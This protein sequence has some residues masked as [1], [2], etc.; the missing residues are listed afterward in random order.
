MNSTKSILNTLT[1]E[2]KAAQMVMVDFSGE[3]ADAE[4][5]ASFKRH[6]WGG[7]ILFPKNLKNAAQTANLLHSLQEI[8]IAQSSLPLLTAVDQE[9]GMTAPLFFATA[10]S[11]GNM[12]IAATG[13]KRYAYEAA[14]LSA[15][16]LVN[17]GFNLNFAPVAD[18]NNNSEN[19][20]I[21]VRSFGDD[22]AQ[23][24]E[25]TAEAVRGFMDG[26]I[27]A[28][29][30][31]FPGHGDTK[32]DSHLLLPSVSHGKER[33]DAV[34]LLPFRA[35]IAAGVDSI[36]TAHILFPA[37][38]TERPA[39]LSP[40]ILSDLLRHEMAF[41]GLII[42][43]SMAMKAIA[44]HYGQ[45]EA[46]VQSVM[47]GADIV[48]AC[49]PQDKQVE[50][51]EAL[52]RSIREKKI[53]P[54]RLDESVSRILRQKTK[55]PPVAPSQYGSSLLSEARTLM[56]TISGES[57]TLV[58]NNKNILPLKSPG[59]LGVLAPLHSGGELLPFFEGLRKRR[60]GSLILEV[61]FESDKT[62]AEIN[63][64][65]FSECSCLLVLTTSRGIM[66]AAQEAL[67]K[68][69]AASGPDVILAAL[70]NPFHL[71]LFPEMDTS[72][73]TYGYRVSSLEAL[74]KVLF[75]ELNP[76]G[77]LPISLPGLF[78]VHGPLSYNVT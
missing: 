43:D 73:A 9:G 49:G 71:S 47:A 32:M 65:R 28:C 46:A 19:P 6:C 5:A 66:P 50:I 33:L 11:P 1:L 78:T 39:T 75:G 76:K 15:L 4:V 29:A 3:E 58:K 77:R 62:L 53:S 57:I 25:L 21:G 44:D 68:E 42:T 16:E 8:S 12:A 37:L 64:E 51:L 52:I 7:A 72:L 67:I 48:L 17:I 22:P 24:A 55:R 41:D 69:L 27:G 31:H 45:G 61:D 59:L 2:Q 35:A 36:M 40:A 74:V 18:I 10:L 20:V 34:E 38:D 54:E 56:K 60:P 14:R 13:N 30:K 70:H 26:G 63:Q 23:V